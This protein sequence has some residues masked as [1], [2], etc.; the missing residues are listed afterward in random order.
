MEK[1]SKP[2][3]LLAMLEITQREGIL[4]AV[5]TADL[6]QAIQQSKFQHALKQYEPVLERVRFLGGMLHRVSTATGRL[7]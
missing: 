2:Q 6:L 5:E 1:L 3:L 4:L 7:T